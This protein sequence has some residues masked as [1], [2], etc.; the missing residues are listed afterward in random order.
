[1]Q[2][3]TQEATSGTDADAK[4]WALA[5]LPTLKEHLEQARALTRATASR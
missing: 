1:V 3:F 5:T 2:L 4:A